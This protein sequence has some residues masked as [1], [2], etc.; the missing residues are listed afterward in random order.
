MSPSLNLLLEADMHCAIYFGI[1]D[2][3][4]ELM[5]PLMNAMESLYTYIYAVHI[6]SF[7]SVRSDAEFIHRY[8]LVLLIHSYTEM[9][10]HIT[11]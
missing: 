10:E 5:T 4:N 7:A 8:I 6:N 1:V 9:T 11:L 2:I 3:L